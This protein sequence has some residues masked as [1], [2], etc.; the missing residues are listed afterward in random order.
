VTAKRGQRVG[1]FERDRHPQ[2]LA[3]AMK[4]EICE[5]GPRE[6]RTERTPEHVGEREPGLLEDA[7]RR[8]RGGGLL[9][10]GTVVRPGFLSGLRER[11][12]PC[13]GKR[14]AYSR[15]FLAWLLLTVEHCK[16]AAVDLADAIGPLDQW[17]ARDHA[18]LLAD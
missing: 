15:L 14:R 7:E 16:A 3:D 13:S 9:Y 2:F 4:S 5:K 17:V 11:L 12:R 10:Y 6:R 8:Q 18:A 1:L